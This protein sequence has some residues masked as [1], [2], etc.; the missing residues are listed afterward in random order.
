MLKITVAACQEWTTEEQK[1]EQTEGPGGHDTGP[2]DR[3]VG[4]G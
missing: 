3:W 1:G 4:S 2:G